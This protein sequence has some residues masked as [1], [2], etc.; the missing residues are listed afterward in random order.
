MTQTQFLY[1]VGY[2]V[3]ALIVSIIAGFCT[4]DITRDNIDWKP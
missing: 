4:G 2:V 1:L 3:A